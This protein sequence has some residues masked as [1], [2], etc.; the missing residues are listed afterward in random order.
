[1]DPRSK[2]RTDP[3]IATSPRPRILKHLSL[4]YFFATKKCVNNCLSLNKLCVRNICPWAIMRVDFC[5]RQLR[6]GRYCLESNKNPAQFSTTPFYN[7]DFDPESRCGYILSLL[8]SGSSLDGPSHSHGQRDIKLLWISLTRIK[9]SPP[10]GLDQSLLDSLAQSLKEKAKRDLDCC[11]YRMRS[12]D[13][14]PNFVPP[15][16]LKPFIVSIARRSD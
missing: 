9:F 12:T 1:M 6:R 7:Y 11:K 8:L 16:A 2:D 15:H 4:I 10:D 3:N 14:V 5:V 13:V